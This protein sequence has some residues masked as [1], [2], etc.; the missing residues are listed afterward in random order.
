MYIITVLKK[1]VLNLKRFFSFL[2]VVM[3]IFSTLIFTGCTNE[4]IKESANIEEI[5]SD[6][7][8]IKNISKVTY[9]MVIQ[10]KYDSASSFSE[11][12]A[13]VGSYEDEDGYIYGYIDKTGKYVI[14][15]KF[16]ESF[17][18]E[19]ESAGNFIDGIARVGG[20]YI[21]KTGKCIT[22]PT[23]S[24]VD[25]F[26]E[27][28]AAAEN[29]NGKWGY[30]DK[31]GKFV[32]DPKFDGTYAFNDGYGIV[33]LDGDYVYIDKNGEAKIFFPNQHFYYLG[34][35]NIDIEEPYSNWILEF[36]EGL[37]AVGILDKD[38]NR[39]W[40]YI[41]KTGE[42]VI[43]PK[44]I[45][46]EG[47]SSYLSNGNVGNFVEGLAP[48]AVEDENGE[49]KYR[50]ID[51]KGEFVIKPKDY[52]E[53]DFS[54]GLKAVGIEDEN[55]KMKYGYVDKTGKFVVE[56]KYYEAGKFSEGLAAVAVK[57]ENGELKWGFIGKKVINYSVI[58]EKIIHDK[59]LKIENAATVV[60]D[61][62]NNKAEITKNLIE[63]LAK[64]ALKEKSIIEK[65]LNK[66]NVK[67]ER[68]L[69]T[70]V[71]INLKN[72]K[73]TINIPLDK[74]VF[75]NIKDI[76]FIRINTDDAKI[77]LDTRTLQQQFKNTDKINIEV[78]KKNK[79]KLG[80]TY[81]VKFTDK[82]RKIIK[83]LPNNIRLI[84]PYATKNANLNSIYY[85]DGKDLQMV[86]GKYNKE[87]NGVE[88]LTKKSGDYY[89]MENVQTFKDISNLDKETQKAIEFMASKGIIEGKDKNSFEPNTI[90]SRADFVSMIVKC[91][92]V[93]D[94]DLRTSF[95]DIGS[96]QIIL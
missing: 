72:A 61:V 1:G 9:D 37:A 10:P 91:F 75:E 6:D 3:I 62:S 48:V 8:A 32:I 93:L 29:N 65:D 39:K 87:K 36:S 63:N 74:K 82:N 17:D 23:I 94:K 51:K 24:F 16:E 81:S 46:Y 21:D 42:F 88:I 92:Y 78:T 40:G 67:L 47:E 7:I 19:F 80:Q 4:E 76:D 64:D 38:K 27:G 54:E 43:E 26:S 89:V 55:G 85:I 49:M 70:T 56:P 84:L 30:I 11:G 18:A 71:N 25:K 15:P 83:K 41:D 34:S 33:N 2:M 31:T 28:L 66:E 35:S 50:Y 59:E 60:L 13:A 53:E 52:G 90:V 69:I 57:D 68:D 5:T 20:L 86:G 12:L 45:Y 14:E 96:R 77:G 44:F 58:P 79:R 22:E 95:K 73:N